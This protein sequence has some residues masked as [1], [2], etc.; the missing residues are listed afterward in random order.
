MNAHPETPNKPLKPEPDPDMAD[1]AGPKETEFK[2]ED[3]AKQM[4][5]ADFDKVP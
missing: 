3:D 5:N 1:E 4:T 2:D